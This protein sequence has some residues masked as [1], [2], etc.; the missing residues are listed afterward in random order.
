MTCLNLHYDTFTFEDQ[1]RQ[2]VLSVLGTQTVTMVY[3]FPHVK[4]K[5][6]ILL[7][8]QTTTR[9]GN[10]IVNILNSKYCLNNIF[11]SSNLH[12]KQNN[13][14]VGYLIPE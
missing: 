10:Y 12:R 7:L 4:H 13:A 8:Y 9:C 5:Q 1:N 2:L 14:E 3:V 6:F 11:L